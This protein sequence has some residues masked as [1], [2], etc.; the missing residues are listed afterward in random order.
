MPVLRSLADITNQEVARVLAEVEPR[1][2]TAPFTPEEKR[3]AYRAAVVRS[4]P[5]EPV[6]QILDRTSPN[7]TPVRLYVPARAAKPF[8]V[9]LYLHGGGFLSGDLATHDPICRLLSNRIPALVAAVE[10][11]LAP[12]HPFPAAIEDCFYVLQWLPS[13]AATLG[14]DPAR[15]FVVGDSAGGN[16]AAVMALLARDHKFPPLAAQV[17]I[18]PMLD[19]AL[20]SPSLVENA[21]LPPFTLV[22]CVHA[23]QL[24]LPDS[25]DRLQPQVS[26]LRAPDLRALPPALVLTAGLDILRDEAIL[27]IQ[28]LREADVPVQHEHFPDMVHGFFQWT[29]QVAAARTALDRIVHYLQSV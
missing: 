24:Y 4:G 8:P 25:V 14:S 16:L 29:G 23:W 18:Y 26:P 5:P 7:G 19:A 28:R 27:Y 11:R 20:S 15:Y 13:Q 3:R 10:Y 2:G 9:L 1:G 22:D 6:A 21:L 12:E 17:L